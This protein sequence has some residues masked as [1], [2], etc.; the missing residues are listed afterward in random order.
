MMEEKLQGIDMGAIENADS[1]GVERSATVWP[2]PVAIVGIGLRFAGDAEDP[3]SFWA[4]LCAGK[5][6][7]TE[8]PA[9]R[10]N[11]AS[12]YAPG[13]RQRGKSKTKWGGF[14]RDIAGFDAEFFGISPREA[15]TLDPQQRMLLEVTWNAFENAG[16]VPANLRGSRTGVFIGGFTL[17]YM[18]MQ[19]G[20]VEYN[21][22]EP[23]TATG[24]MMTLLSNRLSYVYGLNGPSVSL[25]TACS[26]SL[27]AV[28][29]A[30]Q[31]LMH[32]ESDVALAGGVN[33]LLAP[34]YFIAESQAG[35]LSPTGRSR[36]FDSRADGYVRGEGAGIVVLKRLSRAQA[37]NDRIY[38]LIRSSAVNQD[39]H[40]EGLTV[41]SGAAQATLMR[42]A[43]AQAGVAPRN[44][45]FIEAHGTGTPVG[46][47]IE[48]NAIG[49]VVRDGRA[50]H[51][52]CYIG[53]VKTNIGHTEAAAGVAGLIKAALSLHHRALPPH[54]HLQDVNSKID[55]AG[56]RL[57]IPR[58]LTQL[59]QPADQLIAGVNSFGFG[60]TNAHVVLQAVE[61]MPPP[62]DKRVVPRPAIVLPLSARSG[63]ALQVLAQQCARE[64]DRMP[65]ALDA[66]ALAHSLGTRREHHAQRAAVIAADSTELVTALRKFARAE[67]TP[68]VATSITAVQ[69]LDDL[70]WVFTG[71]GPQW[72]GMGQDLYRSEAVFRF[73]LE[74][75]CACFERVA[76]WSLLDEMQKPE[77]R[78]RMAET[79][80]A[81]PANFALQ[82]ALAKLWQSWG[83]RPSAIVGHSAGEPAAAHIA[84]ALSLDDAVAV[85]YHRSRLQQ[86]TT[87]SGRL[88]AVG[89]AEDQARER[90]AAVDATRLSIAAINSPTSVTVAGDD[91]AIEQLR[92][93][94]EGTDVFAK[95][96]HVNVPYHS[97]IMEPL[98]DE[99]LQ[100]LAAISPTPVR[101]PL[102][103][104][105]LGE[106][107]EGPELD[108][109]YWY[110]NVR[111][112]VR[113]FA[114]VSQLI[115]A[116]HRSFLEIG[117]H[118][119][120]AGAIGE[121]LTHF[122]HNGS[123]WCSLRRG[124]PEAATC[125]SAL[126]G[127]YVH[128]AT[129]DWAA[130]YADAPAQRF[131]AFPAYPWQ[132]QRYWSEAPE[133]RAARIER[134][135]HPLLARRVDVPVPLWEGD[136]DY[137]ELAYIADHQIQGAVVFPGA[138]Y[139]EMALAAAR[140]L[141]GG[142]G[143]VELQD[144][145]FSKAMYL[146]H[147]SPMSVRL[148]FE[149]RDAGFTI[150][151]RQYDRPGTPW[152][153]NADGRIVVRHSGSPLAE[154][155]AAVRARCQRT[156]DQESCY[157]HFRT[158]GLEYGPAFQGI[159]Q[160]WQGD[161]EVLARVDL[162]PEVF[163]Q[164]DDYS[165]HPVLFDLCLQTTAATLLMDAAS[166]QVYMP[167]GIGRV[168]LFDVP[169][170]EIFIHTRLISQDAKGLLCD[171]RL[172]DG[173]GRVL[174]AIDGC[175]ARAVGHET[176]VMKIKPQDLYRVA[177]REQP[178]A[179]PAPDMG[180]RGM[181]LIFGDGDELERDLVSA[182]AQ[183]DQ[184]CVSV[185]PGAGFTRENGSYT[186][187][188]AAAE[189]Y[190]TLF[191]DVLRDVVQPL[192]GIVYLWPTTCDT[193]VDAPPAEIDADI[194]RVCVGLLHVLR[195]V[196]R[197][198]WA[199]PPRIW[200]ATRTAQPVTEDGTQLHLLQSALWGLARVAGE[201]EHRDLWGAIVDLDTHYTAQDVKSL[202]NE[203]LGGD[204]EDQVAYRAGVR[205]VPRLTRCNELR[206]PTPPVF[207]SDAT[208]LITGGLGALGLVTARWMV[209]R[210]ARHF[211]L[212]GRE[213]LPPRAEWLSL[214]DTHRAQGRVA[215]VRALEASGASVAVVALDIADAHA[216][217]QCIDEYEG[218][219]RP[220]V[221]GVVHAAGVA[222]PQLLVDMDAQSFRDTLRPKVHGALSL[223]RVFS[224][225]DLDF[226]VMFS[227]IASLV[228]STG[229]GN[230]SAANAFL[231][232][233]AHWR[234]ARGQ[235]G[236]SINWG[237]WGEVGMAAD[238]D[239]V[240][241]FERRGFFA[242]TTH[243]G[244]DAFGSL[245]GQRTAQAA[246][247]AANWQT[248]VSTGFPL[249]NAPGLLRELLAE[250][251]AD[252]DQGQANEA[253][254]DGDYLLHYLAI[255]AAD[256]RR[257]SLEKF[258]TGLA[259]RVLRIDAAK[260]ER[261]DVLNARGMDSMMAI[262]LKNRVERSLRVSIAIVDLLR[263]ASIVS[264]AAKLFAELEAGVEAAHA[265]VADLLQAGAA[266]T[267][268]PQTETE[269]EGAA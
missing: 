239:L 262:E 80:V 184:R 165:I 10:W 222:Q 260:L 162:A 74:R 118:P 39:G 109:G 172:V 254:D 234:L 152:E 29:L 179:P 213:G 150:Y 7:I 214:P 217:Q 144:I 190:V 210:G 252:P 66:T 201:V 267:P 87:N 125:L 120:L 42:E 102:Y 14:T 147:D 28:H 24:S 67:A 6:C 178:L 164:Q 69:S 157:R 159:G 265:E 100:S 204:G 53:S 96:L 112:S 127:L 177:W 227:S 194:D 146:E 130:L 89:L 160:L 64:L 15:E 258:L 94:F 35:M 185:R 149:P 218:D 268:T 225:R 83:I 99:V 161:G 54:V 117:P 31:S 176:G 197:L 8:V 68:E 121:T 129:V 229:Q 34:G 40:S 223:Q 253:G 248:V 263:G 86:R 47:P 135:A 22:V 155:L 206:M 116:G 72:W 110:R 122:G 21:A 167:V 189:D 18:I 70:V 245:F 43:Y 200:S 119:V 46:D 92:Q 12:H 65:A 269:T 198:E 61:T 5:D 81:Q 247:L 158:M 79:Q 36:A 139:V 107:V 251:V 141:H 143:A 195:T 221:S 171:V 232:A 16:M 88:I 51:Q 183:R 60:G 57:A 33:A 256:E 44:V 2:E 187:D 97:H 20:G 236:L 95:V 266:G 128:G 153:T 76:G 75:V 264:I 77:D 124:S 228:V 138:G 193:G 11:V 38:A 202:M 196:A 244:L 4:N 84:G 166:P 249:G 173:E 203:I 45:V 19:L 163:A 105:V 151:S 108:A 131:L 3:E 25:D 136:L 23:H 71:M 49:S 169:Q 41:P 224:A 85:I 140:E 188:P 246:V 259:C 181:W 250:A 90:I 208:Y 59:E 55:L 17:D 192:Q 170:G 145:R 58:T 241:F 175:R 48:A 238:L 111:E 134:A 73:A 101:I 52:P 50:A 56:L 242:M 174:A 132:H 142:L 13:E 231:D 182:L 123:T 103:S 186:I 212:A 211:I 37:D 133:L 27:V 240:E 126:A 113:F 62:L 93:S 205:F 233:L 82:I 106:R 257:D 114:A 98:R 243:Q 168:R 216:L 209:Q 32:G 191:Q 199:I 137:A 261:E 91:A 219:G 154:D 156:L 78:S 220:P 226:F 255:D 230:Y 148:V 235:G 1:V 63:A 207:R 115:Q 104:T 215:A 30:C 9:D 237:P 180:S 26:S